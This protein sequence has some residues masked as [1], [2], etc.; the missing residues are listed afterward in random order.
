MIRS[1]DG[2]LQFI[3]PLKSSLSCGLSEAH[4]SKKCY[5]PEPF[6]TLFLDDAFVLNNLKSL[7]ISLQARFYE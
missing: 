1:I 5:L 3:Q 6:L 4:P 7:K 2:F